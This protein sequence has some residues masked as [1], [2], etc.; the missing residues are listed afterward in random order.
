MKEVVQAAQRWFKLREEENRELE[1]WK[2][3]QPR[4]WNRQHECWE[5]H[6]SPAVRKGLI[7][8]L[9]AAEHALE[10]AVKRLA[11]K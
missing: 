6:P 1:A 10:R 8:E 7:R 9:V 5:N 2:H 4:T 3:W 11:A